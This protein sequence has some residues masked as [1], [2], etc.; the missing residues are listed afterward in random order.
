[1]VKVCPDCGAR[2]G[3]LHDLFCLKERCPFCGRQLATCDCIARVL[4]LSDEEHRALEEFVDD[5]VPPLSSILQRWRDT[6]NSKGR[7][8]FEAYEDDPFRAAGRGDLAAVRELLDDGL[9]PNTRNEAG[10]TPL[11]AAARGL[12]VEVIRLLLSRGADATLADHDGDTALHCAVLQSTKDGARE[13]ACVRLLI[14]AGAQPNARNANGR[15]PLM[16]ATCSECVEGVRELLLR[17]ADSTAVE[18]EGRTARELA[19]E[20]D[21][22]E[23]VQLFDEYR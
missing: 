14:D 9:S 2:N 5:T 13:A 6:L 12:Q 17:G 18:K 7:I 19:I 22:R 3:Q 16:Q 21:L 20:F 10:Y 11:M 4:H 23:M 1:M 8:P 15:T